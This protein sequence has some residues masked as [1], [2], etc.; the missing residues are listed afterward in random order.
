MSWAEQEW[1]VRGAGTGGPGPNEWNAGNVAASNVFD[2]PLS[3][4]RDGA[5]GAWS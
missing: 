3:L 4:A 5:S 1:D 2:L